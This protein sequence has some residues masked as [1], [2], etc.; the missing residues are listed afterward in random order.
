MICV[1]GKMGVGKSTVARIISEL[2]GFPVVDVDKVGHEVL[3]SHAEDIAKEFGSDLVV[4]GN[5]D[6]KRLGKIV[7]SDAEKLKKLESILHPEMVEIVRERVG[8]FKDAVVDCALLERMKLVD[9]CD[10]IITVVSDL[11]TAAE[12]KK[13]PA[14]DMKRIWDLQEDIRPIGTVVENRGDIQDLKKRVESI[15]SRYRKRS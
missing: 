11:K 8:R 5:V 3:K 6:R 9:I 14:E 7:F 12:R 4:N 13:I 10:V 2:T 15:I 1:T